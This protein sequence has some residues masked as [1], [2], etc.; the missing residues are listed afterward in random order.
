MFVSNRAVFLE[1]EFL[2]EG[3]NDCKIELNEVHEV[4]GPTHTELNLIGE[5]N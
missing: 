3:A 4:R 2:G 5:S 1:K